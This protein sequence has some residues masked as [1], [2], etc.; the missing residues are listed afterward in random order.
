MRR[1]AV[2]LDALEEGGRAGRDQFGF[3]VGAVRTTARRQG[4]VEEIRLKHDRLAKMR[5]FMPP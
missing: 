3:A 5:A 2:A 4:H 1:D